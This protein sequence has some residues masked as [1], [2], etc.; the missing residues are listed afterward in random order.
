MLKLILQLALGA[1]A[2]AII[3]IFLF[4]DV[5]D[6][7]MAGQ[8]GS[9]LITVVSVTVIFVL[10]II[11]HEL[12]H[13]VFGLLT[14]FRF[15]SF[16]LGSFVWYKEDGRI[17]FSVSANIAAGQCLM[18]P[19]DDP[20]DFRF[21]LYNLGGGF[22]NLLFCLPLLTLILMLPP[23]SFWS[24]QFVT[25]ITV[26]IF[27]ALANLIPIKP[28][29][30]DGANVWEALK[31]KDATRG[32]YMMLYMNSQLTEGKRFRDFDQ[33]LFKVSEGADLSNYMV[34]YTVMLEAA[35]LEDM[36]LHDEF[37]KLC[38]SLDLK[39]LP[40]LYSALIKADLLYYHIVYSPDFDKAREIYKDKKLLKFLKSNLPTLMR[41]SAA[42]EFF[43]LE[44]KEKG[45]D[46]LAKARKGTENL[47]NK[48]QRIMEA[49]YI[50]KLEEM[51]EE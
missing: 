8:L 17:R 3:A 36:G 19:P 23:G 31:S 15:S 20:K 34:A 37:A 18:V 7:N 43:V 24:G 22:F 14:G 40:S 2:G 39:K 25:G 28:I 12:G 13:L 1:V 4:G 30:N 38:A 45:R 21:V 29:T 33:A 47:P 9:V 16:K 11:I 10:G 41:I 51:M 32:M 42:Y 27:L 6:G 46:L 48:G 49:E 5:G 26:N 50:E 35:R 44:N